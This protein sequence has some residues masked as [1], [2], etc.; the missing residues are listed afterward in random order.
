LHSPLTAAT[1]GRLVSTR[2]CSATALMAGRIASPRNVPERAGHCLTRMLPSRGHFV[3]QLSI[4][5]GDWRPGVLFTNCPHINASRWTT[6]AV[7]IGDRAFGERLLL[8]WYVADYKAFPVRSKS[9]L[10]RPDL[11]PPGRGAQRR[12]WEKRSHPEPGAGALAA[13]M[14]RMASSGPSPT[15]RTAAHLIP[16]GRPFLWDERD[17]TVTLRIAVGAAR[18]HRPKERRRIPVDARFPDARL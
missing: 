8:R 5:G 17:S 10:S 14:A 16:V 4:G 11:A 15:L 18:D 12:G 1:C 13:S 9:L 3:N 6:Y 7:A 2:G